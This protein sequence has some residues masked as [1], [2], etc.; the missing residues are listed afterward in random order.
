MQFL[1]EHLNVTMWK[2]NIS[3]EKKEKKMLEPFLAYSK[4]SV[5]IKGKKARRKG[6]NV[7]AQQL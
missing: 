3:K 1:Y 5:S 4:C 2:L 7:G 6:N